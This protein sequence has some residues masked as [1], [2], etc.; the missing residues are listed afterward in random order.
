MAEIPR[1][2]DVWPAVAFIG[3]AYTAGAAAGGAG[4][5]YTTILCAQKRWRC[6]V[7]GQAGTGFTTRGPGTRGES[8]FV[9]RLSAVSKDGKPEIIVAQGGADTQSDPAQLAAAVTDFIQTSKRMYPDAQLYIIGT[10]VGPR[11]DRVAIRRTTETVERAASLL[12]VAFVDPNED[13]WM[14]DPAL[15]SEDG[16]TL[17]QRGYRAYAERLGA[18]IP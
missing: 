4:N 17:N 9:Q 12:G 15:F 18:Y 2:D 3:D 5:R 6:S 14:K 1:T 8:E 13:N 16:I 10:L 11:S 7:N